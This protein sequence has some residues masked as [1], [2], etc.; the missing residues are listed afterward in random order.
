HTILFVSRIEDVGDNPRAVGT[1]LGEPIRE[2]TQSLDLGIADGFRWKRV[3]RHVV[4]KIE[5]I[6][7]D[8]PSSERRTDTVDEHLRTEASAAD[9]GNAGVTGSGPSIVPGG[10]LARELEDR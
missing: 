6:V 2:V 5:V 7:D 8:C 4:R 3:A 1:A 9:S 10:G